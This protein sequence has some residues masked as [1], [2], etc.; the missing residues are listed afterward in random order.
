MS[1]TLNGAGTRTTIRSLPE[2]D[3]A[4]IV[5]GPSDRAPLNHT[6]SREADQAIPRAIDAFASVVLLRE[7]SMTT[8]SP[9]PRT[10]GAAA[11]KKAILSPVGETRIDQIE[12]A[13]D[14]PVLWQRVESLKAPLMVT[15]DIDHAEQLAHAAPFE[16][17]II[18]LE[19]PN[20]EMAAAVWRRGHAGWART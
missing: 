8:S 5:G 12:G 19:T 3:T 14:W 17:A 11:S 15:V 2:S 9:A 16:P 13:V 20:D 10:D 7:R 18:R 4:R 1:S 6:S